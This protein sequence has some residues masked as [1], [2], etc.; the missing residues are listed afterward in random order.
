MLD[1]SRILEVINRQIDKKIKSGAQIEVTYAQVYGVVWDSDAG[2]YTASVYLAGSR[3]LAMS[4]GEEAV[5][6]E[7]F[8]VPSHLYVQPS[9]YVRVSMDLRGHRWVDE[10]FAPQVSG[11]GVPGGVADHGML[12]GLLD[13]DH[14]QYTTD[15]EVAVIASAYANAYVWK[16]IMA[17]NP[18]VI[19]TDGSAVWVPLVT[20]DGEAIMARTP[21]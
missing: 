21:A 4:S 15:A 18:H 5:P 16:P 14:P 7:D 13:D 11:P 10:V 9:D 6:S 19:T 17:S 2:F 20:V 12:S 1:A 8:R 3:E